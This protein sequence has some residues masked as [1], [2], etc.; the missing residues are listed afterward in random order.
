MQGGAGRARRGAVQAGQGQGEEEQRRAPP[1]WR[2]PPV[3]WDQHFGDRL[4]FF[5][6]VGNLDPIVTKGWES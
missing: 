3:R 4:R 1:P 5:E 6:K 2:S